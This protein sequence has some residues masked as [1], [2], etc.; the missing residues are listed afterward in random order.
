MVDFG[1]ALYEKEKRE[2]NPFYDNHVFSK[3]DLERV[4]K[5]IK[6]YDWSWWF[7]KKYV[8]VNEGYIFFYKFRKDGC[9]FIYKITDNKIK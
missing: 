7:A 3:S 8:Q 2:E 6:W 1:K 4:I 5:P 9:I